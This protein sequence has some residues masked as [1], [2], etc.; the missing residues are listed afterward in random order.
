MAYPTTIAYQPT[1]PFLGVQPIQTTSTVQNHPLGTIVRAQ[2]PV[3]GEGEFIYAKGVASTAAGDFCTFNT[4]SVPAS[5]R[6]VA[7]SVG[8]AGIAMSANVASQYGWYQISGAGV[9]ASASATIDTVCGT[10]ATPGTLGNT[11]ATVRV[12]GARF[13]TAQGAPGIGFTG[14]QLNR[15]NC[16]LDG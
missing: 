7:A 6:T 9:V 8:P 2:D 1:Q 4:G 13:T 11:G 14:V 12:D 15:P 10:T 3:Y 16:N 5:V